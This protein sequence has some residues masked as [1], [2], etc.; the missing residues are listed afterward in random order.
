[1][2]MTQ[3]HSNSSTGKLNMLETTLNYLPSIFILQ[4]TSQ[5]IAWFTAFN[6]SPK[7][8]CIKLSKYWRS[9]HLHHSSLQCL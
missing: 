3:K 4:H 7:A 8:T 9:V 6:T 1:M 2:V 5:W